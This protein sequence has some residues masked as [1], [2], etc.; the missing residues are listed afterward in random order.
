MFTKKFHEKKDI[1]GANTTDNK[2]MNVVFFVGVVIT[3]LV[4]MF[5]LYLYAF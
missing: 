5:G 1:G 3:L 2:F 4:A